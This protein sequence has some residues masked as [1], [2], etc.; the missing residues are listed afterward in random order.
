M[1]IVIVGAGLSGCTLAERFASEGHTITLLEK[2]DHVAGNCYDY[3]NE[4]GILMS[5]YG[6]HFFHT[7]STRVWD[8][9]NRFSDWVPYKHRTVGTY[10]GK[11]FPIPVNI[12]TV[13]TLLGKNIQ[14]EAEMRTF[15]DTVQE[16]QTNPTNSEEVA[17]SRVGRDL[18]ETIF[19]G[20]TKKQWE[21]EPSE[22]D[23]SVLA[24]IPVRYTFED[25]YFN[26]VFQALPKEGYTALCKKM[27]ANPLITVEVSTEYDPEKHKGDLVFYTGPIDFY[28]RDKGLPALEYR[29]LRFEIEERPEEYFQ[30]N[31]LMNYT[32]AAVPYTRICEYKHLLNQKAEGTTIVKEYPT[33]TG[34]PYYPIPSQRNLELYEQYKQLSLEE[35]GVYF[36]GRL[37]NYKYFNMDQAIENALDVFESFN[38]AK[39]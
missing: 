36:V 20:Y 12:T 32:D 3:V 4:K 7:A 9:V 28:F 39:N 19:R 2:R 13:N 22:L 27:L 30:Q 21:L 25:G 6:P 15:M 1:K 26:D 14:T 23:P 24:R 11:T 33:A 29:S 37:A 16:P 18:Y 38:L 17:L 8:Y 31:S 5:K 10:K 35:K 34:E